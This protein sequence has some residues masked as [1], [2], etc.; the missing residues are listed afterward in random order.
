MSTPQIQLVEQVVALG[1]HPAETQLFMHTLGRGIPDIDCR[2]CDF[3]KAQRLQSGDDCLHDQ[4]TYAFAPIVAAP[5]GDGRVFR[6]DG[7]IADGGE[8]PTDLCFDIVHLAY[9]GKMAAHPLHIIKIRDV[10]LVEDPF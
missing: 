10:C 2:A 8:V 9:S 7:D 3:L 4:R 6:L 5:D 1:I